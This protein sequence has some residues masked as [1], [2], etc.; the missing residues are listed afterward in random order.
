PHPGVTAPARIVRYAGYAGLGQLGGPILMLAVLWP[1]RLSRRGPGRLLWIGLGVVGASTLAMLGLQAPYPTGASM[2]D[3][4]AG[5]LG[6][7]AGSRVG[8]ALLARL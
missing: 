6:D 1:A 5:D 8:I 3:V 2:F 7:V 4:S